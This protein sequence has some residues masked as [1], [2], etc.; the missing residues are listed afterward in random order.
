MIRQQSAAAAK[1]AETIHEKKGRYHNGKACEGRGDARAEFRNAKHHV[2]CADA[3]I[4][5][6]GLVDPRLIVEIGNHDRAALDH[7]TGRFGIAGFIRISKRNCAKPV[8]KPKSYNA[9][10]TQK[11]CCCLQMNCHGKCVSERDVFQALCSVLRHS[12][13]SLS[14]LFF[15]DQ[16]DIV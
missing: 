2:A 7:L 4:I 8:E 3:P 1:S 13:S 11:N 15:S 9:Q 6:D 12:F 10:Q 16:Y 5:Q 14:L